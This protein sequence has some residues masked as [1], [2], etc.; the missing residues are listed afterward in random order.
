L[1]VVGT[2]GDLAAQSV[3]PRFGR[4][5][6]KSDAPPPQSNIMTY[7]PFGRDGMKVTVQSVN[8]KGDT[9]RWWYTTTF[10][11]K[12]MPVTGN[13]SQ[14]HAAVTR[15]SPYVNEIVNKRNGTVMQRL[16]NVLSRDHQT[17]AVM[18]MRED[19]TGR[20]AGVTFAT[21]VRLPEAPATPAPV[22]GESFDVLLTGGTVFD[23]TGRPGI[24]A[25]VGIR[26][27]RIVR[28]GNLAGATAA[29]RLDVRGRLV[30]PGFLNI[31]SHAEVP[32][33]R[34][35]VNMLSQGV[36]T[37]LLNADGGGP[38]DLSKQLTQL[39]DSGLA[40]NVAASVPFNAIWTSVMG[41]TNHRATPEE[42]AR[43][44]ALVETGLSAGGFGVSAGLD[45]KP[46]YFATV[47]EVTAVLAGTREWRTFFTNHDRL[48]PETGYSSLVGMEETRAI[49]EATGLVP[50]YTHMKLQGRSQGQAPEWLRRMRASRDAG[51]W[52]GADVYPYLA[53]QTA[54]AALIIPGWAQ[55][56]GIEAMRTRFRDPVLR[57]RIIRE[58]DEAMTARFSGPAEILLNDDNTT[59][60]QVMERTGI[61]SPGE[62]VVR[63]LETR[64]PSAILGFGSEKDLVQFIADPDISI[65]C[66]C[67]AAMGN[68]F[69]PRYYGT[70]PRVLGRY[71]REQR[72]LTWEAAIRKMTGLPAALL[73]LTDRGFLQEGMA[74]D[75]VVIDSATVMDHATYA[76]PTRPSTGIV[77]VLVNGQLAW[78]DGQAT[79]VRAGVALRRTRDMPSR[80]L[81]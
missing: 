30:A 56:G 50:V 62:A 9:S 70:F 63:V 47:P 12:D 7:E 46:A 24:I 10:D 13:P 68:R 29:T 14:T 42:I 78:R 49:G 21:Y 15:V 25:D 17:I 1:A 71:V 57:A 31:H 27:H 52:S 77:H 67:G 73:G 36:T 41:T 32:A 55:E 5:L 53:G 3:N 48:T 59:L 64:M 8:A 22:A 61:R 74:A 37:E 26:G 4:W 60:A 45:Y 11:G 28:I 66:D 43:M 35:A 51:R 39:A 44:R 40:V 20:T 34:S 81:P 6:L 16:T 19:A 69:H 76:E 23:G 79:G 72:L 2:A 58:A 65:A 80:R 18:Y 54:L 33:L 38:I 75:V